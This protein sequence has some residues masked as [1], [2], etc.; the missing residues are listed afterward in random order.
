MFKLEDDYRIKLHAK[1]KQSTSLVDNTVRRWDA[2]CMTHVCCPSTSV[3]RRPDGPFSVRIS[4][5]HLGT[6]AGVSRSDE[7]GIGAH[8]RVHARNTRDATVCGSRLSPKRNDASAEFLI[9]SQSSPMRL[10]HVSDSFGDLVLRTLAVVQSVGFYAPVYGVLSLL[11]TNA[12]FT[13]IPRNWNSHSL[14]SA[15]PSTRASDRSRFWAGKTTPVASDIDV[16]VAKI[17][18]PSYCRTSRPVFLL[19]WKLICHRRLSARAPTF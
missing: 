9:G 3:H 14:Y 7:T 11:G 4:G 13:S 17:G 1:K 5:S 6:R 19:H 10:R 8:M 18:F 15:R 16:V 2:R 12:S